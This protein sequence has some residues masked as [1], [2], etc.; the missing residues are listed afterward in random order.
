MT[1]GDPL[2][3]GDASPPAPVSLG[4]RGAVS[5]S[6]AE[7]ESSVRSEAGHRSPRQVPAEAN[8]KSPGAVKLP[9]DTGSGIV[10]VG[11]YEP[12]YEVARC[13][14]RRVRASSSYNGFHASTSASRL[15]IRH[16]PSAH[17]RISSWYRPKPPKAG[18]EP[19]PETTNST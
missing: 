1:T 12:I 5:I 3:V 10:T 4:I 15:A 9:R 14:C 8:S 11:M 6:V 2:L 19:G 13:M 17:R 16:F 18:K 7:P